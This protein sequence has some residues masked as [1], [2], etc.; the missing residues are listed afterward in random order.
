[1]RNTRING[2]QFVGRFLF[3]GMQRHPIPSFFVWDSTSAVML[4]DLSAL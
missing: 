1:V 2:L 4:Y 3:V